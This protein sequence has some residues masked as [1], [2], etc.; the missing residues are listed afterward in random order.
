MVA[1]NQCALVSLLP[2]EVAQKMDLQGPPPCS[3]S[4][5][6]ATIA[7]TWRGEEKPKKR[8]ILADAPFPP[9]HK[10]VWFSFLQLGCSS[11]FICRYYLLHK[12]YNSQ[13]RIQDWFLLFLGFSS[14]R[15]K[16]LLVIC[17]VPEVFDQWKAENI[18]SGLY[19][20]GPYGLA[21]SRLWVR[22]A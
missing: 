8:C 3:F 10:A 17:K 1:V 15:V 20:T 4:S 6:F 19:L 18:S 14:S 5:E 21:R 9:W 16:L 22:D 13:W 2:G 12:N 11:G 7:Q